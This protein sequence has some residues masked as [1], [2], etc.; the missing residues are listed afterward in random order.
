MLMKFWH[1]VSDGQRA[2]SKPSRKDSSLK[3]QILAV[4]YRLE[5]DGE[6]DL[7]A[8]VPAAQPSLARR[9]ATTEKPL[10]SPK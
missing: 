9:S 10:G 1:W 4:P 6:R 7:M 2:V 8:E 3:T 5:R